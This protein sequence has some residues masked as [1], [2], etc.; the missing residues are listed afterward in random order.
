VL[1]YEVQ[2]FAVSREQ[3]YYIGKPVGDETGELLSFIPISFHL[4]C[5]LFPIAGG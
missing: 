1:W 2:I 4:S 3:L 5:E